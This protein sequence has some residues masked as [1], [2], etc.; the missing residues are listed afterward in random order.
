MRF[1]TS[2]L[3]FG[4]KNVVEFCE[5]PWPDVEAMNNGLIERWNSVVGYNDDVFC[6]GDMFFC[7][8][9][10]A[11]EYMSRLNGLKYLV[12]GNH[13]WGKVKIHRANEFGFE[14]VQRHQ[15]CIR[16]GNEDVILHHFPYEDDHTEE[17]RFL[18]ERPINNGA[19]LLHGHV[20]RL[21]KVKNNQINVGVDVW[22]WKPIPESVIVEI[23]KRP[24]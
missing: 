20:H 13:D 22:D 9:I 1:F 12:Q 8:T 24:S 23:M 21:W 2:D 11:K 3:H 16:I 15:H 18:D 19:W 17:K 5:R 4:H 10:K 6:L 7:G 14:W